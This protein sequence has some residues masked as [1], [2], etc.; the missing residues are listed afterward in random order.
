MEVKS[1]FP[2]CK[3]SSLSEKK[4]KTGNTSLFSLEALT[5]IPV[6][7]HLAANRPSGSWKSGSTEASRITS[8]AKTDTLLPLWNPLN[9]NHKK[10]QW[11]ETNLMEPTPNG[12]V[13]TS[14]WKYRRTSTPH[15]SYTKT[16]WLRAMAPTHSTRSPREN[17]HMP[18]PSPP[19]ICM[20]YEQITINQ[21]VC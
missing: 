19:N 16:E 8:S 11:Q 21:D 6:A 7:L 12:N 13:L 14:S 15:S 1:G 17:C 2:N 9:E 18:S 3:R 5:L 4:K 10:N 20:L